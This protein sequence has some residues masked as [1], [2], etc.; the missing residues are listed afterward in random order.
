MRLWITLLFG[1]FA[2]AW[3]KGEVDLPTDYRSEQIFLA[4]QSTVLSPGDTIKIEGVVTCQAHD[5]MLP[6]SRY[7]YIELIN[8]SD[9]VLTRQ[10]I[11]CDERG[12]FRAHIPTDSVTLGQHYLRAYTRLMRNFSLQSF[13]QLPVSFRRPGSTARD[14]NYMSAT[15][16]PDG[17][18]LVPDIPQR[19]TV[20]VT[21][22]E[23]LPIEG[24]NV[25]LSDSGGVAI[26]HSETTRSGYA[27]FNFLPE[28]ELHIV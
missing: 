14:D 27:I 13:A 23:G 26:G 20:A 17:G 11:A 1:L 22:S 4:P 18:V 7:L 9:I 19:L 28:P 6:Y 25:T 5:R 16:H 2:T 21:T 10:K 24:V 3:C 8:G 12:Y 15:V